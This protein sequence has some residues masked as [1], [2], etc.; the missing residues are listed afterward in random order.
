MTTTENDE[1]ERSEDR[2][3]EGEDRPQEPVANGEVERD[4][5]DEKEFADLGGLSFQLDGTM[6]VCQHYVVGGSRLTVGVEQ[7]VAPSPPWPPPPGEDARRRLSRLLK[8]VRIR[9]SV[10]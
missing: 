9:L 10:A 6:L 4:P 5:T 7:L 2:P 8:T 3:D 1:P